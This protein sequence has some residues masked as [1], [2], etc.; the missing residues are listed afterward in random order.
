M[1]RYA[2]LAQLKVSKNS[3]VNTRQAVGIMGTTGGST[4]IHLHYETW[5]AN[6]SSSL[7]SGTVPRNPVLIHSD[8]IIL[9][10]SNDFEISNR[11]NSNFTTKYAII[12][13]QEDGYGIYK[14]DKFIS[15]DYLLN[16]SISDIISHNIVSSDLTRLIT[17]T[18]GK[19]SND[20]VENLEKLYNNMK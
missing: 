11:F 9:Y 18:K 1:T 6:S 2:H 20:Q 16:S 10:R 5:E 3:N 13:I 8:N 4:G 7:W 17:E 12:G 19:I 15:I 14:A